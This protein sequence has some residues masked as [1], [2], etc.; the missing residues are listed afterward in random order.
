MNSRLLIAAAALLLFVCAACRSSTE[1][2]II[3]SASGMYGTAWLAEYSSHLI[4]VESQNSGLGEL[5]K[6]ESVPVEPGWWSALERLL[7]EERFIELPAKIQQTPATDGTITIVTDDMELRIETHERVVRKVCGF[8][9]DIKF[10]SDGK[11]FA[12]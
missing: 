6:G 12:K 8:T 5:T 4:S 7:S 3:V 1:P 11:R 10:S 9:T 2:R